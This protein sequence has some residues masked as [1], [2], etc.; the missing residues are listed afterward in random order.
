[1]KLDIKKI[2][3]ITYISFVIIFCANESRAQ[4]VNQYSGVTGRLTDVVMLDSVTAIVVGENGSVLKTIDAGETWNH[5]EPV[6]DDITGWNAVSFYNES[7]GIV[8]GKYNHQIMVTPNAGEEW[9]F[10]EPGSEVNE[11][12][13]ALYLSPGYIY[14]GDDSGRVW[15]STDSGKTWTSEHVASQAIRSIFPWRGAYIE[16]LPIY[17]LT[18]FSLF[19]KMEFPSSSWSEV[20]MDYFKALGSAAFKGEFSFGGGP[21]FIVGTWGDFTYTPAIVRN[22]LND[23]TWQPVS[24]NFGIGALY[25]LSAPSSDIIYA[26]GTSGMILKTTDGGDNWSSLNTPTSRS[27]NSIYFFDEDRG[28]AVGDSGTILF[29]NNGG[30]EITAVDNNS[31]TLPDELLLQQNYPNPF[32]PSTNITYSLPKS[33]FVTLKIYNLNGEEVSVLLNKEMRSGTYNVTWDAHGLP[34][35]IYLYK[36]SIDNNYAV[37]KMVLVK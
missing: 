31:L 8:V 26:C 29:T 16:S 1:M 35:G 22:Q 20:Q 28:F 4:W 24:L 11:F 30:G 15:I 3:Y 33:G 10:R 36:I 21:G 14:A 32:N 27:L 37:R 5:K 6:I 12:L 13:S 25:D 34:S 18:P 23:T 17:A 2:S 7:E 19:M 9:I